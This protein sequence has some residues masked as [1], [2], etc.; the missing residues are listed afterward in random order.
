MDL[1]CIYRDILRA[2]DESSYIETIHNKKEKNKYLKEL[3]D[4][5]ETE[6]KN[7]KEILGDE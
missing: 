2:I 5:L 6:T 1:E 4:I 3:L 7:I